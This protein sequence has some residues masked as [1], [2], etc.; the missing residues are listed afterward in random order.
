MPEAPARLYLRELIRRVAAHPRG[1][2]W[3]HRGN[4]EAVSVSLGLHP[5]IVD[6]ARAL[7]DTADGRAW[8]IAEAGRIRRQLEREAPQRCLCAAPV[9]KPPHTAAELVRAAGAH[10]LGVSFLLDG[11]PEAVAIIFHVHPEL[12]L[13]AR[14]V[15]E[16]RERRNVSDRPSVGGVLGTRNP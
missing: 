7:L 10:P 2:A 11:Y 5:Y 9:P 16:R 1:L 3:L 6:R 12:V 15:F 8:L 4:L 14:R 13:R